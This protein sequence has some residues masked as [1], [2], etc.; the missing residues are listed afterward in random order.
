MIHL[1]KKFQQ[2]V[3]LIVVKSPSLDEEELSRLNHYVWVTFMMLPITF[4]TGVYNA[5]IHNY[6]LAF[7]VTFFS[8]Y[9][10]LSLFLV[11]KTKDTYLLY[12]GANLIFTFL[13]IYMTYHSDQDA[14]RILWVYTYP[15]GTIFLFGNRVGFLWSCFL[16]LII[17]SIFLFVP[18]IQEVYTTAFKVRFCVTYLCV[19]FITSWIEY[20]RYR[21]QHE[22]KHTHQALFVEQINL[23][24]EIQRRI[25]LE[26]KLQKLAQTDTLTGLHNRRYFLERAEQELLRAQRYHFAISFAL[27]DIDY[28]KQINDTFGH[29]IGDIVLKTLGEYCLTHMRE[30][31][32]IG[33]LGGE[34]LAFLLLHTNEEQA[35]QKMEQLRLALSQL[36]IVYNQDAEPLR[37]TASI[38]I[39]ALSHDI[40]TFEELYLRVDKKLYEA[41]NAGRNC[42]R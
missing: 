38:G 18:H 16:L 21:Y 35:R 36:E 15:L 5:S 19:A 8:T 28:F 1:A 34:E 23:K 24:D 6:M 17:V 32:I 33:R 27:L 29:P 39:A 26:E 31:D 40:N 12:H 25:V 42:I 13:M 30:T 2:L 3:D 41:K 37:I 14:S 7:L 4:I 20:H 22:S 10:V 9:L 11:S